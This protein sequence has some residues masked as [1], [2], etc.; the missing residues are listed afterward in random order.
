MATLNAPSLGDILAEAIKNKMTTAT[1]ANTLAG[2]GLSF[3][4]EEKAEI[5][6]TKLVL[7]NKAVSFYD[8]LRRSISWSDTI[9]K[10]KMA[11]LNLNSFDLFRFYISGG[12]IGAIM[13]DYEYNDIDIYFFD[14]NVVGFWSWFF[15]SSLNMPN[16]NLN[17]VKVEENDYDEF[18]AQRVSEGFLAVRTDNSVSITHP[19]WK[20]RYNLIMRWAG[21]PEQIVPTTFDMRHC[22]AYFKFDA[23][24]SVHNNVLSISPAIYRAIKNRQM[25]FDAAMPNPKRIKKYW[26]RGYNFGSEWSWT[27]PNTTAKY[28][29][30]PNMSTS[31][32]EYII[33]QAVVD[34]NKVTTKKGV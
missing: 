20:D 12:A 6:G 22:M 11:A 10:A 14:R 30:S 26:Y 28:I 2:A 3:T 18:V 9:I 5:L 7:F 24:K 19:D 13:G 8:V 15:N 17:V 27:I 31:D 23:N 4:D 32:K 33:N 25:Y 21:P 1:G 16:L 29:I 34:Y